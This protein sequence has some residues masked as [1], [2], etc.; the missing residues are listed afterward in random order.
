MPTVVVDKSCVFTEEIF[1]FVCFE[2]RVFVPVIE[3]GIGLF[4]AVLFDL[5]GRT[6]P[7]VASPVVVACGDGCF[8]AHEPGGPSGHALKFVGDRKLINP[9]F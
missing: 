1:N 9:G 4:L 3:R 5:G 6:V 2:P 7:Y 8:Y